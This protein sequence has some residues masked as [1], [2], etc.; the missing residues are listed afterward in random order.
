MC[1]F[2]Q[3]NIFASEFQCLEKLLFKFKKYLNTTTKNYK[4]SK[5]F[6]K[7]NYQLT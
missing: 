7:S 1:F 4:Q 5:H 6:R 3:Y 2:F